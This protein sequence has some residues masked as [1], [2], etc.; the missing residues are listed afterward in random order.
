MASGAL[1]SCVITSKDI[2]DFNNKHNKLLFA[3]M[4]YKI[5][6]TLRIRLPNDYAIKAVE[7]P[8]SFTR[9]IKISHKELAIIGS[10]AVVA[11]NPKVT[12]RFWS[13]FK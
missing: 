4:D 5:G 1:D 10:A 12:R 9:E 11:N 8:K 6:S 7:L 13:W 2:E 3:N